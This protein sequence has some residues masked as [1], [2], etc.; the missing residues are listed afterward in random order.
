MDLELV[1]NVRAGANMDNVGAHI[2][3]RVLP[4]GAGYVGG[5][6]VSGVAVE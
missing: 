6:Y 2:V 1:E 4:T 5:D 3:K